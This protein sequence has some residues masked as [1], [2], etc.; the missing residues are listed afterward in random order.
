MVSIGLS[1]GAVARIR[2]AVSCLWEV[3]SSVRVMREPGGHA[4]HLPWVTKVRPRL[5]AVGLVG[6]DTGLLW[7][8]VRARP[9]YVPD[10]LTPPVAD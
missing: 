7:Q 5:A 10:F 2:F 1:A 9:D 3:M 4:V 6:A 8:L